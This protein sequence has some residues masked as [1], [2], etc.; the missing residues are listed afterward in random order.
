M[1][2]R[3]VGFFFLVAPF[4]VAPALAVALRLL[5][6]LPGGVLVVSIAF[7]A[8]AFAAR[9]IASRTLGVWPYRALVALSVPAWFA[10]LSLAAVAYMA[11]AL[12]RHVTHGSEY[13]WEPETF[14]SQKTCRGRDH[15][16]MQGRLRYA[17]TRGVPK[18]EVCQ[19]LLQNPASVPCEDRKFAKVHCPA[20]FAE[21]WHCFGC[22]RFAATGDFYRTWH[23]LR[24]DCSE[25]VGWRS[26]NVTVAEMPERLR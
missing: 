20:T 21:G 24:G 19:G 12:D 7:V 10:T 14:A 3:R 8:A 18:P 1:G 15:S 13:C 25:V 23:F 5:G 9:G 22:E 6:S 11:M 17:E 16:L 2:A 26:V 4:F